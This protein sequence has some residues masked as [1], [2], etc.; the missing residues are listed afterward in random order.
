MCRRKG[1]S[2]GAQPVPPPL[3]EITGSENSGDPKPE[4]C[5][6]KGTLCGQEQGPPD[7]EIDQPLGFWT[8]PKIS[9]CWADMGRV[10]AGQAEIPGWWII[11]CGQNFYLL[12]SLERTARKEL[13]LSTSRPQGPPVPHRQLCPSPHCPE[14]QGASL[15]LEPTPTCHSTISPPRR[16]GMSGTGLD[17]PPWGLQIQA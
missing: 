13:P 2:C 14:P 8:H 1:L 10:H 17:L 6:E 3:L 15:A 9:K 16:G 5:M 7:R 4:R 11:C 12:I